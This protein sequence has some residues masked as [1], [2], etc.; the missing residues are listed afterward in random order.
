MTL[1]AR[2]S[3]AFVLVVLVPLVVG[4]MLVGHAFPRGV[5]DQVARQLGNVASGAAGVLE[6]Y[7]QR[8]RGAAE[9]LARSGT[10]PG[11]AATATEL[12][13]RGHAD[14]VSVVDSSG[15]PLATAGSLPDAVRSG[16]NDLG[17]CRSGP[18]GS[19]YVIAARAP[20]QTADGRAVGVAYAAFALDAG[21]VATIQRDATTHITLVSGDL[22]VASSLAAG[23]A[24]R[25]R[26]L[27][28]AA[29]TRTRSAADVVLA[30]VPP[31][32]GRSVTVVTSHAGTTTPGYWLMATLIVLVITALAG[33][34]GWQLARVI[35][36]PLSELGDAAARVTAGDLDIHLPVRSGDEV[37][38]L[39]TVFNG[40]TAELRTYIRALETSRDELRSNLARLGDT[41]S[42]THD[43]NRI[44]TVILE[45][46]M[47]SVRAEAGAVLLL[48][49]SR[50]ELFL[51]ASRGLP[52]PDPATNGRIRL[53]D[54]VTGRVAATGEPARGRVGTSAGDL[55]LTADEPVGRSVISVP[56][57]SS[58][59]V[60]GV[61]NLYDRIDADEFDDSDLAT[62]R[63][64]AGQ[65]TV[66]V[67]NV[68]LHQEAQRLSITDGLTG[69]WNYRY[70][71]MN[72]S[73]EIERAARFGRPL[74]LLM[75]DLD[76]FKSVNDTHGH[77]RG[78][79]VLVELATRVKAEI[80]EVDT[81]ARYGGEEFVL[82]LPETDL[83]GASH[84]A[85]RIAQVIRGRPFGAEHEQPL[86]VT[87]SIGVSIFPVHGT[88]AAT[89]LSRADEALY[90]A[91]AAGR[92]TWCRAEN[93]PLELE[94]SA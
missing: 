42:S 22:V 15:R 74:A 72:F 89:L 6:Q 8:A 16:S 55:R 1:R 24:R 20:M 69:L 57:K 90:A 41:L 94:A 77:Q 56:L 26:D 79:S 38:R 17:D 21:L 73:K 5:D 64:F 51:K 87:V 46:A 25:I 80:R 31:G 91:K 4:S 61:L 43:L 39:A 19:P 92:D 78:D 49:T 70:F 13:G 52:D 60:I 54:G 27:A 35:T 3:L 86:T 68:L 88:A 2:L 44:L 7:C 75:F 14:F 37:G 62:I 76:R 11:A 34:I 50:T 30:A 36:H 59:R 40:M 81:L 53:G 93:R 63:T 47:G 33:G 32:V 85:E 29:G 82:V 45:T 71:T 58:G 48:S 9:R 23:D 83:E 10:A 28:P 12:V 18:G 84:A 66:A 65:A 67:D